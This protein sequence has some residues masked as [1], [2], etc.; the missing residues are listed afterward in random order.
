M[1]TMVEQIK[2]VEY[3]ILNLGWLPNHKQS[4]KLNGLIQDL[5]SSSIILLPL[6]QR[7]KFALFCQWQ[8]KQKYNIHSWTNGTP[9]TTHNLSLYLYHSLWNCNWLCQETALKSMEAR[10]FLVEDQIALKQFSV[11]WLA[12]QENLAEFLTKHHQAT[13]H[14]KVGPHSI[15]TDHSSSYLPWVMHQVSCESVLNKWIH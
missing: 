12:N 7:L 2:N 4:F 13:K 10:N 8:R 15:H 5:N 1:H 6:Q 9:P 14:T 11:N 3:R